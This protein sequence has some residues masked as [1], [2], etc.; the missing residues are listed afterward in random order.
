MCKFKEK[1]KR[2]SSKGGIHRRCL[3]RENLAPR[4]NFGQ[5]KF[6][7]KISHR[8]FFSAEKWAVITSCCF[9]VW[10]FSQWT[11][12]CFLSST[13][14]HGFPQLGK[15]T[16]PPKKWAMVRIRASACLLSE[17]D[18]S[19]KLCRSYE[20]LSWHDI[21]L[22]LNVMICVT[23]TTLLPFHKLISE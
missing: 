8:Q 21:N 12:F 18:N 5:L 17:S 16:F 15:S 1:N 3:H 19:A 23:L 13:T 7:W 22:R 11:K 6:F 2:H 14:R 9:F 4:N 10:Q 20:S